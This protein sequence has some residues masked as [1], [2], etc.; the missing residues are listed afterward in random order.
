MDRRKLDK[1]IR[2]LE[3]CGRSATKLSELEDLARRLGRERRAKRRGEP[4]WDSTVFDHL[5]PIAIPGHPSR[6]VRP[7]T[8]TTILALLWDDVAAWEEV[9]QAEAQT[10]ENEEE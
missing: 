7:G 5:D 1:I 9:L 10:D 8:K 4:M 6:D 2:D 3:R